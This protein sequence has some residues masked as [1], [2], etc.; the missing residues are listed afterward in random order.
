MLKGNIGKAD[1]YPLGP[2][3][4]G[5]TDV[6]LGGISRD[7]LALVTLLLQESEYNL[8][9]VFRSYSFTSYFLISS[10]VEILRTADAAA[11]DGQQHRAE[12]RPGN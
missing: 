9:V 10:L 8:S 11:A 1:S 3:H 6:M 7:P 12:L 4:G 2:F 5:K